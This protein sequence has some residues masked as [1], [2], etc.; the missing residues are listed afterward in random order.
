MKRVLILMALAV[1]G[2]SALA[3]T[4]P[5]VLAPVVR[6]QFLDSSGKPLAG[7]KVFTY[8]AGTTTP[9]ATYTD[10]TG[11]VPNSNP[12]I[13]DAGGFAGIWIGPNFYKFVVQNH[14][15]VIQ[16]TV[17]NVSS[18]SGGGGG[19]GGFSPAIAY[20]FTALETFAA[21]V[22]ANQ[23]TVGTATSGTGCI[24]YKD[25]LWDH[26][27][28]QCAPSVLSADST[29]T[30]SPDNGVVPV[31]TSTPTA[32]V[33]VKSVDANGGQQNSQMTDD[34]TA[35]VK[36]PNGYDVGT[37]GAYNYQ[38]PNNT[39]TGTTVTMAAC[40]DGAGKA[41]IC[42]FSTSTADVP[43]GFVVSGAGTT[44]NAVLCAMGFCQV[45]FDNSTTA[46]HYAIVSPT[47]NGE[48]HDAG[49]V[50]TAGQPNFYIWTANVGAG[51][52]AEVKLLPDD[53]LKASSSSG[54]TSV[55]ATS[56][57]NSSGGATPNISPANANAGFIWAGPAV[58]PGT[59][60][61]LVQTCSNFTNSSV[62]SITATCGQAITATDTIVILAMASTGGSADTITLTG[63]GNT[64]VSD[65]AL[66]AG[67]PFGAVTQFSHVASAIGGNT[68]FTASNSTNFPIFMIV[69]EYRG[70]GAKDVA[71]ACAFFNIVSNGCSLTTTHTND[72]IVSIGIGSNASTS[73]TNT[74]GAFA[75]QLSLNNTSAG[76]NNSAAAMDAGAASI[77]TYTSTTNTAGAS[78]GA[79]IFMIAFQST[80]TPSGPII[81]RRLVASDLPT[82][83][84]FD[85]TRDQLAQ[86]AAITD[87]TMVT[88]TANAAYFFSGVIDCTTSSA[89]ATATLNLKWTDTSSTAQSYTAL[90]TCT[91]LGAASFNDLERMIRVKSG[92]NITYGVTIANTPTYDVSVRLKQQ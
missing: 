58:V 88:T 48:L 7:G 80:S 87:T 13:L 38:V 39:S 77:G 60:A 25:F 32:N 2:I 27:V 37:A 63:G 17:D 26:S 73:V 29:Q 50:L 72:L 19:G 86:T 90:A 83:A 64:F 4:P 10:A 1:A 68:T 53:F 91:T 57:I 56:P 44:G 59:N 12:I 5:P 40:N 21:G 74:N 8:A 82:I 52:A 42:P 35:P 61:S 6:Q 43:I 85:F 28:T 78:Q 89:S 76:T 47:V 79:G 18:S 81:P 16:Y 92:T 55:T 46:G 20:T 24:A 9:L 23:I 65:E 75:T 70:A 22:Q 45:K 69:M 14:N 11:L 30:F 36:S 54:V 41:I 84:N 66:G 33:L 34:G 67:I 51:T 31:V 3:Q 15:S 62:A 49:A 71:N